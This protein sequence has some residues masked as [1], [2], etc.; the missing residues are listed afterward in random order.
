MSP[1]AYGG[2]E[3]SPRALIEAERIVAH[4]SPAASWVLMV[5]GAH[6]FIAGRLP[7]RC[8]DEVFGPDAGR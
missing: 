4:G 3:A 1:A 7:R 8:Q 5:C 6:T 2:Y